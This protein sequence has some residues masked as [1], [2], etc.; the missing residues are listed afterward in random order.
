MNLEQWQAKVRLQAGHLNVDV[1]AQVAGEAM[2]C[3]VRGALPEPGQAARGS[4]HAQ[5]GAVRLAT[6]WVLDEAGLAS[7][8]LRVQTQV[9]N[10]TGRLAWDQVSRTGTIDLASPQVQRKGVSCQD[11][12]ARCALGEEGI[13]YLLTSRL[14]S[15]H[16]KVEGHYPPRPFQ[17]GDNPDGLVSV[18]AVE[19]G[20]IGRA[21][22]IRSVGEQLRGTAALHLPYRHEVGRSWPTGRGSFE[23]RHLR[24]Q[25]AEISEQ[26]RG[27]V[28]L[29]D[30]GLLLREIFGMVGGGSL[31]LAGGF[32]FGQ[33]AP[34]WFDLRLQG[35][36]IGRT[37]LLE[38][39]RRS[40][41][42]GPVDLNFRGHLGAECRGSGSV[43]LLRGR[44][45]GIEVSDWR[46]PV[47][48]TWIPSRGA[49]EIHIRESGAQ[50]G[51]GRATLRMSLRQM[52]GWQVDGQVT[53]VEAT[54]RSLAGLL[55]DV[56]NYARGRVSGRI[57][58][59]G[60]DLQS[61]TDVTA[62]VQAKLSDAQM[63]QLPI[64]RLIVP[65]SVPGQGTLEFQSGEL[66]GRL[67]Q[68]VFRIAELVLDSSLLQL[69]VQ[70]SATLQGRLDLEVT[71]Q[72][73][74]PT[75]NPLGLRWILQ[76][77]P[78]IGPV[79]VGLLVRAT[80]ALADRVIHLRITGTLRS[81]RVQV[82]PVRVLSDQAVRFFLNRAI[83]TTGH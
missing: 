8:D 58:F 41:I 14:F 26:L 54:L 70:G 82:E 6:G 72:T 47:E 32:R 5:C 49:T 20:A 80:E 21:L 73:T 19:L 11:L 81:P 52:G 57:D 71:G 18:K 44:I 17:I 25:E 28:R 33:Q 39:E 4:L 69:V 34:G 55:G 38:E 53:L 15:G 64:L 76:Q 78:P 23:V 42:Q 10:F 67:S 83:Q 13:D 1:G 35:V 66:R 62:N 61:L 79:P 51:S 48:F 65:H 24:W 3:Q 37:D 59:S 12:H 16:L 75:I 56:S 22:G 29:T 30:E 2:T 60:T 27:D 40:L 7:R 63:L 31:R 77:L 45:L 36:E 9:G 74:S 46:V 50:I 68:G 43:T